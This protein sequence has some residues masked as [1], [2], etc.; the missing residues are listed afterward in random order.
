MPNHVAAIAS[1]LGSFAL[2]PAFLEE[3]AAMAFA[4]ILL[5][6]TIYN[7]FLFSNDNFEFEILDRS[8]VVPSLPVMKV[9]TVGA[10]ARLVPGVLVL[11][12]VGGVLVFVRGIH[13]CWIHAWEMSHQ[14]YIASVFLKLACL[15]MHLRLSLHEY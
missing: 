2:Q 5:D 6:L 4:A 13:V 10:P 1:G 11:V 7:I 8:E 3:A 12:L 15:I 14:S 9:A